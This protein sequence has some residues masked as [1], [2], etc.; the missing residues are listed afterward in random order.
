MVLIP[1]WLVIPVLIFILVGVVMLAKLLFM[2]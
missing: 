2:R 1:I